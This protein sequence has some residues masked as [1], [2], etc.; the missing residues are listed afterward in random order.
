ME[1]PN[2]TALEGALPVLLKQLRLARFRSQWQQAEQDAR[3]G[4]WD[5]AGYLYV[6]AELEVQKRREV[7]LER[8]LRQAQLPVARS[9]GEFD[10]SALPDLPRGAIEAMAEDTGW[11]ERGE[12]LLLFG[13]S[14]VGK[15]H[16]AC[17]ICRRL[18][19]QD[20]GVRFFAATALVQQ[21]QQAKRELALSRAL[22][23]LDRYGLLVI[24]D[25]GYV[26]RSEAETSVL[27]ELISHRYERRSLL[28]TSNQPFSDW[29]QV[30]DNTAM[31][32]A[33]VDRLVDNST[34]I[35]I[36][37]Q[38]YRRRRSR[39]AALVGQPPSQP[40]GRGPRSHLQA[41]VRPAADGERAIP[42]QN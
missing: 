29:E 40:I 7:R 23:R 24:D 31:S 30:F 10:W 14:G 27:F 12:N 20:R 42:A 3:A 1:P 2:R 38:S 33:A 17:G 34:V 11:I 6:L 9:L 8:L 28:V 4:G 19:E 15:T 18:I 21:L 39:G 5:P 26:R 36:E 22:Q 13:P 25:M 16:L 41:N 37:G 32:V 35:V